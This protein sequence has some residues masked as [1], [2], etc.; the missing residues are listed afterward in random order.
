MKIYI[1]FE[2]GNLDEKAYLSISAVA[3]RINVSRT[4]LSRLLARTNNCVI[5]KWR[6]VRLEVVKNRARGKTIG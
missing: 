5:N 4:Y 1:V 2:R 3:E 6:V